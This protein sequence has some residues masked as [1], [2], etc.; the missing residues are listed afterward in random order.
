MPSSTPSRFVELILRKPLWHPSNPE[1]TTWRN[2]GKPRRSRSTTR[3][4][5]FASPMPRSIP[6]S[7]RPDLSVADGEF[8]AIVGPTGCG[9]STL[10]NV[11]AGLLRPV[12]G[13]GADFRCAADRPQSRGRLSVSGRRAVS[14]EDRAR[15]CRDRARDRGHAARAG[16][17][18]GAG[19]A[20][21]GRSRR[22]RRPLSAHA[23]GRPAQ[24]GRSG[25]GAD[26][27][28]QDPA[29]GRAVRAARCA[30]P[31]DHGQSAAAAMERRPQGGVVR[32]PR[33]R[34][35]DRAGGSRRDHV[36]GPER[37]H[38]RRLAGAAAAAARYLRS[39]AGQGFPRAASGN[40][41]RAEG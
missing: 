6:R 31:A 11:A 30:D 18:A 2:T 35:G 21:L 9:K 41:G 40:L 26:P 39:A 33:S 25:A 23:V 38:H 10:L 34:R 15:Q 13:R 14:V 12:V 32:H 19:L 1:E 29:D 3:R 28:P 36:G 5:R 27:R 16:A 37:A 17:G 24:A 7:K 4:W 22:V 8:V 20:D